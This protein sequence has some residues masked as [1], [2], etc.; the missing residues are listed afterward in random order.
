M[1]YKECLLNMSRELKTC[2]QDENVVLRSSLQSMSR[3]RNKS[4]QCNSNLQV[5]CICTKRQRSYINDLEKSVITL[6][7]FKRKNEKK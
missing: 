6:W 2:I 3:A 7:K 5:Q 1:L 4:E